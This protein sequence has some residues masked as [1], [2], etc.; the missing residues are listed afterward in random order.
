MW[1]SYMANWWTI[2]VRGP[3]PMDSE[4]LRNEQGYNVED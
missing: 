1:S 4:L 3:Q 2:G